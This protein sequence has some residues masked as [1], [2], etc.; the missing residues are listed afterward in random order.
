MV[1]HSFSHTANSPLYYEQKPKK[2]QESSGSEC[3]SRRASASTPNT[4]TSSTRSTATPIKQTMAAHH[5]PWAAT[6]SPVPRANDS[7]PIK[8]AKATVSTAHPYTKQE[9]NTRGTTET[10]LMYLPHLPHFLHLTNNVNG[11]RWRAQNDSLVGLLRSR[12]RS[13]L[14]QTTDVSSEKTK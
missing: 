3:W 13:Q 7:A 10:S 12:K 5:N 2:V 11:G 8:T 4:P 14:P 9:K 1:L 6:R